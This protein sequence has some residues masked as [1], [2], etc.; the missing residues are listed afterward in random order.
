MQP[1]FTLTPINIDV[2]RYI[3]IHNKMTSEADGGTIC[4]RNGKI[5]SFK[6][7]EDTDSMRLAM[8]AQLDGENKACAEASQQI[9]FGELLIELLP[10]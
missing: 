6:A 1:E 4:L 10:V 8:K 2:G 7:H 5:T 3:Y 9:I